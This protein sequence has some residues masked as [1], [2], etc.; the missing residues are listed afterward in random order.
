METYDKVKN[1]LVDEKDKIVEY[2]T[3]SWAD[4]KTQLATNAE[5]VTELFNKIVA[6]LVN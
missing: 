3:Q 5:Q 6:P 1:F 4:A 2:Q